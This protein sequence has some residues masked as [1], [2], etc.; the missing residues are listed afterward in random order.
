MVT[1]V[2]LRLH[3]ASPFSGADLCPRRCLDPHV[4]L[5]RCLPCPV[6]AEPLL[7]AVLGHPIQEAAHGVAEIKRAAIHEPSRLATQDPF[8]EPVLA[9]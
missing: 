2:S 5:P 1:C 4:V 7:E 9:F 3:S 8:L 6:F